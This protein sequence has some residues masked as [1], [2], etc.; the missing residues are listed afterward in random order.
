MDTPSESWDPEFLQALQQ[1]KNLWSRV[2]SRKVARWVF[3]DRSLHGNRRV[4]RTLAK[5]SSDVA[6]ILV[7]REA[8]KQGVAQD[9]L[10]VMEEGLQTSVAIRDLIPD[11]TLL[12]KYLRQLLMSNLSDYFRHLDYAMDTLY[13]EDAS[14]E[15]FAVSVPVVREEAQFTPLVELFLRNLPP[16]V[17]WLSISLRGFD[18]KEVHPATID[19]EMEY[20]QESIPIRFADRELVYPI[21]RPSRWA[22]VIE[23]FPLTLCIQGAE[24]EVRQLS[25]VQVFAIGNDLF[26]D[27]R[28]MAWPKETASRVMEFRL[29]TGE[30]AKLHLEI[31]PADELRLERLEES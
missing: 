7:Y 27:F 13:G 24:E 9:C 18:P 11:N 19:F 6:V 20:I 1:E 3:A 26:L 16:R 12:G 30:T 8:V 31:R 29:K 5:Q 25:A 22:G 14:I 4:I 23:R 28:Y 21:Q 10:L 17:D 2:L 15:P